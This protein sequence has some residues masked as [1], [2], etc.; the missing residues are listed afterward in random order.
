MLLAADRRAVELGGTPSA[1]LRTQVGELADLLVA[2]A[3]EAV[4]HRTEEVGQA[5]APA[6]LRD[7]TDRLSS[8]RAARREV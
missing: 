2:L 1:A 6:T 8:L 5:S 4:E 3:V 7:A